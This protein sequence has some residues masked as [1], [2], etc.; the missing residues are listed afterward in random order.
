MFFNFS[1]SVQI[2]LVACVTIEITLGCC[3]P[4]EV[5]DFIELQKFGTIA[6]LKVIL[7][8]YYRDNI[9][10]IITTMNDDWF[11]TRKEELIKIMRS[12]ARTGNIVFYAQGISTSTVIF[13]QVV[14]NLPFFTPG[15]KLNTTNG[16][17]EIIF[18]RMLPQRTKCLFM[19]VSSTSYAL[20]YFLQ[21]IQLI[22]TGLGN[23]GTDIFF[24][25]LAMHVSGQLEILKQELAEFQGLNNLNENKLRI[26]TLSKR[27]Q[28]LLDDV[29]SLERTFNL[30][31]LVQLAINITGISLFGEYKISL[32]QRLALKL[33]PCFKNFVNQQKKIFFANNF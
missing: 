12:Y 7:V 15:V 24:F 4:E 19:N 33:T 11:V 17:E 8:R 2:S 20:V 25:S 26:V 16:T 30:I 1:N 6:A 18:E 10:R 32:Y 21:S 14:G 13:F 27:H 23:V 28:K 9:A 31:I 22:C 5:I 3:N 29:Q